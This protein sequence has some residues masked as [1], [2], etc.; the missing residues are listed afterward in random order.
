MIFDFKKNKFSEFQQF[1]EKPFIIGTDKILSVQQ[2]IELHLQL[3]QKLTSL[4][5][6]T[7]H[8]VCIFGEKE[9]L[10]P[11]AMITLISMNMPYV[12]IDAIMPTGRIENIK[13][14]IGSKVLINCS[15]KPCEV[16]FEICINKNIEYLQDNIITNYPLL[17]NGNDPIRYIL[18]TSG[19]T[20]KPKG[21][22]ITKS[23]LNSFIDWYLTWPLI[24]ESSIFMNQA[25]FSF[26]VSLCDFI[27]A[28]GKGSSIILNDYSLLKSG[29]AFL[30]RLKTYAAT[31]LVCTPSFVLIYLSVP[32]FNS[33]YFPAINQ[34]IFMGEE[35]PVSTIKKLKQKFPKVKMVNAFGPT[36]ATIVVTYIEVT[37][38][39][40]RQ[41]PKALPIGYCRP[42]AEIII[43]NKDEATGIGELGI[44]GPNLS[45]GYLNDNDKTSTAFTTE[46][47]KRIYKTGDIGYRKGNLFFYLGRNDNQVKLNG[48]RIEL[49]E[50]S[51]VLLTHPLVTN[52]VAVPLQNGHVTKKIIAF[53]IADKTLFKNINVELKN[54]LSQFMPSYMIPSEF[55][56]KTEFP[57]NSNYKTDK[58]ALLNSY[59]N[60]N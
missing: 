19:S 22:Q 47:K 12:P 11:V 36:E 58:K 21:V 35:L 27:A 51:N 42:N 53:I 31:T 8:P 54:Y 17:L 3:K 46:S 26:D 18:F 2:V 16:S 44:V 50:I 37:D 34:F 52:A 10:F 9:A 48:Y 43:L 41:Y 39:I 24:E 45:I 20:G 57:L 7:G 32:E 6:P 56:V 55:I 59:I 4:K 13:E 28:F 29:I 40:L 23:A 49:E 30:E 15:G 14:Q 25:P 38:E 5:I 1:S 60:H 33:E